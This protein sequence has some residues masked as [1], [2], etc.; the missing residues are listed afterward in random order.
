MKIVCQW[1]RLSWKVVTIYTNSCQKIQ[2]KFDLLWTI[3]L[4]G[5]FCLYKLEINAKNRKFLCEMCNIS[6]SREKPQPHFMCFQSP[7]L[8]VSF[9]R[10][11]VT[12]TGIRV[13]SNLLFVGLFCS[14]RS[15]PRPWKLNQNT[16]YYYYLFS[17]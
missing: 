12:M 3:D 8:P 17:V 11:D 5:L 1:C 9:S 4:W 6:Y 15:W 16:F 10:W 7:E 13:Y 14:N 2:K